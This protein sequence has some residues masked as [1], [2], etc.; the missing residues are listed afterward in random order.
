MQFAKS[1]QLPVF[2]A[3]ESQEAVKSWWAARPAF[4]FQVV[5]G[6]PSLSRP[7]PLVQT[8]PGFRRDLT[9]ADKIRLLRTKIAAPVTLEMINCA[10]SSVD[11]H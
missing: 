2:E 1:Q 10:L 8:V 5:M 9:R 11:S 7:A 3:F 6:T 4:E